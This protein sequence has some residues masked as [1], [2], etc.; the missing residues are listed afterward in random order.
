MRLLNTSTLE[1]H[2]F[3]GEAIP[4]YAILSHR[5]ETEEV[6]FED[7]QA[8]KSVDLMKGFSKIKG[9]CKQAALDFWEYAWVDSCC[10]RET[11]T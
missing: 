4:S 9:C 3:Y 2:E 8:G 7:L 6:T 1:L 11:S 5:W 10:I